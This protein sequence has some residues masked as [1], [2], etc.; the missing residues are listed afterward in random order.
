MI[1]H[2]RETDVTTLCENPSPRP[3]K[4]FADVAAIH[5]FAGLCVIL[6]S[7]NDQ[8]PSLNEVSQNPVI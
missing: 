4:S 7:S 1:E 5:S 2:A 8:V 6:G 3:E